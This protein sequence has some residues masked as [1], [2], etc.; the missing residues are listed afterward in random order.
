METIGFIIYHKQATSARTRFLRRDDGCLF[1]T[2]T[3]QNGDVVTHPNSLLLTVG[4]S[5]NLAPADLTYVSEELGGTDAA[6]GL[7]NVYLAELTTIDP[8]FETAEKTGCHFA[9]ILE[10]R[11]LPPL[12]LDL[13][14]EAYGRIMGG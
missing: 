7:Q 13:L 2:K 5:L 11:D 8:P 6:G 4:E 10:S 12:E 1:T 3:E 14:G 9:S